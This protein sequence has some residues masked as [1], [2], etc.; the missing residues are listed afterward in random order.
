M[1]QAVSK[2][3]DRPLGFFVRNL[4]DVEYAAGGNTGGSRHHRAA[5][6]FSQPADL[7]DKTAT[8]R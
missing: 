1:M 5:H 3:S 8:C 7:M 6:R 4:F 2:G